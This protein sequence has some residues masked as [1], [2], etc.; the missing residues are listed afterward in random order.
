MIIELR[1]SW[2]KMEAHQISILAARDLGSFT[3]S[4]SCFLLVLAPFT[5][6]MTDVNNDGHLD[7]IVAYY[8]RRIVHR[9]TVR[10]R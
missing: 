2:R 1:S 10:L 9:S 7:L 3:I 6:S 8:V 5:L 4:N